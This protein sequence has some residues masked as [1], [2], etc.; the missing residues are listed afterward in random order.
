MNNEELRDKYKKTV[1]GLKSGTFK[2]VIFII[3]VGIS[4]AAGIPDFRSKRG[5]F[6]QTK[7]RYGLSRP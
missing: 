7:K 2:N 1:T 6:E 4:K 3:G 5:L